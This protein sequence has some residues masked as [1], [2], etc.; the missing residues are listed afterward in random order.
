MVT[1]IYIYIYIYDSKAKCFS[2]LPAM[3]AGCLLEQGVLGGE[4]PLLSPHTFQ[5]GT[6]QVSNFRALCRSP[7][8]SVC[9]GS[10]SFR[11]NTSARL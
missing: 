4:C 2:A 7:G 3:A 8:P 6:S 9:P 5:A 1:T 11:N 10:S